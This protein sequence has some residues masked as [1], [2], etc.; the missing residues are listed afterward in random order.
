MDHSCMLFI[1]L[2]DFFTF[3]IPK[4]NK[5]IVTGKEFLGNRPK[6]TVS[7]PILMFFV[8]CLKSSINTAPNFDNLIIASRKKQ[9]SIAWISNGSNFG[10]MCSCNGDLFILVIILPEFNSSITRAG[11]NKRSI[12]ME[13]QI[14][15][16]PLNKKTI[17]LCPVYFLGAVLSLRS[18]MKKEVSNPAEAIYL[19][20]GCKSNAMIDY[21]WP[22]KIFS[23][24]GSSCIF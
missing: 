6:L 2:N 17:T 19:H 22:F 20:L 4:I 3:N 7:N 14:Q 9:I 23:K 8:L 1:L 16:L 21:L 10:L 18:H 12:G 15:N 24:D 13:L 5:T 11:S